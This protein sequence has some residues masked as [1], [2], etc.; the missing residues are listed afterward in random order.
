M[1]KREQFEQFAS[2]PSVV[3]EAKVT[4]TVSEARVAE[5]EHKIEEATIQES[6]QVSQ[7]D[8]EGFIID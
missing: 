1:R 8:F 7:Y 4:S 6:Y 2:T 5:I 3:S